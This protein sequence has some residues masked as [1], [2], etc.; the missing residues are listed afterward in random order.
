MTAASHPA[1]IP[2]A[3][4]VL[5]FTAAFLPGYKA[6]GPIKSLVYTL[7]RLPDS[8]RVT[9]VTAD[10][11]LG[12]T[13]PYKGLSGRFVRRDP[14]EIYYMN[15]RNPRH[16]MAL[17]RWLRR[18]PIDL[19]YVNSLWSPLFAVLPVTARRLGLLKSRELLIAPQGQL[20]QGALQIKSAKKRLFLRGWAPL[21]RRIDPMWQASTKMEESDIQRLFPEARIVIQADSNGDVPRAQIIPSS[22]RARFVFISRIAEMKNLFLVLHALGTVRAELDFDIYG[23]VEDIGYWRQC[24][25]LIADLP[26]NVKVRYLGELRPD[27]VSDTFAQHDAFILPTRGENF[28]HVIAESL[29]A[30]C[31]VICSQHTHWTNVLNQGGGTALA[32]LDLGSWAS[33]ISL[34]A[35]QGPAQRDRAKQAAL[36]AYTEWREGVKQQLAITQAFETMERHAE[37]GTK[38]FRI[39]LVT[40]GYQS[41]GGVPTVAHWLT[42][43]LRG[44]GFEVDVFD[45]ATSRSDTYSRRLASPKS[46]RRPTLL[47]PDPSDVQII[48]VGANAVEFEPL[49]YLP[50]AEFSAELNRFDLVQVVSGAPSLA[51]AASRCHRPIA[52]MVATTVGSERKSQLATLGPAM[53]VWRHTMTKATSLMERR[54]LRRADAVLVLNRRMQAYVS[55]VGQNR[56]ILAPPGIDT[57]RFTPRTNG[58]DS[59]GYLLSVCRLDD[60]RKGLDRLV[61]SYALMT[62]LLSSVPDLIVAGR[63]EFPRKLT[64]LIRELGVADRV[65]VRS[66]VPQSEL[67]LLYRGASVYVQTSHEEGLGISIL[68]AMASGLPV[69]STE[70]AGTLETVADGES[71]WLV[72]Q[73]SDIE[74]GIAARVLQVLDRDGH[75]MSLSARTRAESIFS[76]QVT[77]SRFLEVYD[78]LIDSGAGRDHLR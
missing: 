37:E 60:E 68:E 56:V 65:S 41:A 74:V 76:D 63:G 71:G 57:E 58:W 54:A 36:D 38:T 75:T 67:P 62:K 40:Q 18:N 64:Q 11:D 19:I 42:N 26:G 69:V 13:A 61:R 10:R 24:Q 22:E 73:D 2:N 66:D 39:A 16:W 32:D 48:H 47:M 72:R 7:D 78:Q 59:S 46:W 17:L 45:L 43:R 52:L 44:K 5:V 51:L 6:G 31:P 21:L 12:D 4:R 30:G 53:A 34:R 29:S 35:R 33:E 20:S 1:G 27:Q 55:S 77:I 23:P 3:R 70:T 25:S 50:R 15:A 14:H 28:G 8:V 9:I 49:R